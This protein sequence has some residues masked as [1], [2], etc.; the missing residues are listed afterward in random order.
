MKLFV[1]RVISAGVLA[2]AVAATAQAGPRRSLPDQVDVS[3]YYLT[4]SDFGGPY[5]AMAQGAVPPHTPVR[6]LLPRQVTMIVRESGF[7]P[8]GLPRQRGLTYTVAV[9]NGRGEDGHLVIDARN[10]RLVRFLPSSGM[11]GD[12]IDDE[13]APD[14]PVVRAP[15]PHPEAALPAPPLP[16]P[17]AASVPT[18]PPRPLAPPPRLANRSP[19]VPAPKLP[20]AAAEPMPA[21]PLAAAPAPAPAAAQQSATAQPRPADAAPAEV[22]T[23]QAPPKPSARILPTQPM[24]QAQGLD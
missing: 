2:T 9:I 13:L 16:S 14:L 17:P 23:G 12:G 20:R 21:V 10:G 18:A 22:T 11:M 7:F 3:P 4:V 15:P 1:G 19:A 8:L 24:P 6:L 5:D